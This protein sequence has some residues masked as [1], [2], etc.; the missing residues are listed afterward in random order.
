MLRNVSFVLVLA[1]L[2]A[3]VAA[4]P[5][6]RQKTHKAAPPAVRT[7][8]S[9]HPTPRH[10]SS[11]NPGHRAKG[12][13]HPRTAH[14]TDHNRSAHPT[15]RHPKKKPA[16]LRRRPQFEPRAGSGARS[17]LRAEAISLR[18][19]STMAGSP[20]RG[21]L[22]SLERQNQIVEAEGLE[23]IQDEDDL[24]NRIAEK[25]L[26][27]VPVSAGLAVNEEL[28]EAHRYCRPWTALFL[29]NLARAHAAR[30][31]RPIEVSSAV[32]TVEY[33]KR[34]M[35]T[36]GNAAAAEGDIV[37]PHLTGATVDVA[38]H[39]MTHQELVWMR[40]WL[41]PLQLAGQIDAEEEFHQACFHITVY[42]L[43]AP[44]LEAAPL[45]KAGRQGIASGQADAG[46]Q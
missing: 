3:T 33:Q 17:V 13:S 24:N 31:H 12:P 34:L 18:R 21:S 6:V 39:G 40:S 8:R 41:L 23:R 2:A 10:P 25:A 46:G 36:N 4:A 19:G 7:H 43:Y 45:R 35:R 30:F 11:H 16:E 15:P 42:K 9:A 22:E 29:R 5:L 14:P 28:P 44:P 1:T 27:P 32:R 37:S 20:L 26:I 38:K